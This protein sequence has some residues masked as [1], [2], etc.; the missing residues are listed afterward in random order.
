MLNTKRNAHEGFT[1]AAVAPTMRYLPS[2][3]YVIIAQRRSYIGGTGSC[4]LLPSY[5]LPEFHIHGKGILQNRKK[6]H[7]I[8]MKAFL[9]L[10][11]IH[12]NFFLGN[13]NK[14]PS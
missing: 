6:L 4:P 1:P 10:D 8:N 12:L 2:R 9:S 14:N 3:C 7:F 11:V 5:Q 13:P